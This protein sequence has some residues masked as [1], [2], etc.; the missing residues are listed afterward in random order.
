MLHELRVKLYRKIRFKTWYRKMYH[1][2]SWRNRLD[3]VIRG[4]KSPQELSDRRYYR[5]L[6]RD[7]IHCLMKYGAYYEEYFSFGFEG[8][9][10]AYRSSFI[11]EGIRMS[12]YPRMNDPKNTDSLENKYRAYKRFKDLYKRDVICIRK[13]DEETGDAVSVLTEF[14]AKHE[15][16]VVK[17]IYA[18]FGKGVHIEGLSDYE[19]PLAAYRAYHE[20]GAV[21]EELIEQGAAM[22]EIHPQSVNT[23]RIPT[24]IIKGADGGPEVQLFNPT[25]RVGRHGSVIDN[26]S[27]GG[28]TAL[29]DPESGVVFTDG[30]DK[31][32]NSYELH[33]DTLVRFK[34]YR[35]PHWGEA[36]AM[37]KQA[38]LTVEGNHYCGWDLAYTA[39]RGWCMVEC[40]STAQMGGMQ[41]VTKTGRRAELEALIARM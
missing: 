34:G 14:G 35:I 13:R 39:E 4:H 41:I 26:F 40:N 6:K 20:H 21:L 29:I 8:K 25:L 27:A 36:V 7:M 24:V 38:A 5:K 32:G 23:L 17:P 37:V 11:T 9:D 2:H 1:Y 22:A 31:K 30:V 33:P 28:I 16:Y 18:A 19:S 10:E 3:G 12:F 15:R